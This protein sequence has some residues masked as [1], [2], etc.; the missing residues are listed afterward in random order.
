MSDNNKNLVYQLLP[1][2]IGNA[3]SISWNRFNNFLLFN[4]IL[5]LAWT[6]IYAKAEW[7]HLLLSSLSVVGLVISF[8]WCA[9]GLRGRNNVN[10]FLKIGKNI[11]S[12]HQGDIKPLTDAVNLRDTQSF[13][14]SGS[15][16]VLTMTPLLIALLYT[17]FLWLSIPQL[18]IKIIFISVSITLI[19]VFIR[20]T[21]GYIRR[22]K[23]NV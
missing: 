14:W 20:L 19:I 3:E 10:L 1:T 21:L 16:Y 2:L 12:T 23:K 13:S 17:L 6:T 22:N 5:I 15:I 18:I 8:V 9:L 11:E 7:P 4:S